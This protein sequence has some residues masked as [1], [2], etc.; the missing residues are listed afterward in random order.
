MVRTSRLSEQIAHTLSGYYIKIIYWSSFA[1]LRITSRVSLITKCIALCGN[2]G[3]IEIHADLG[4]AERWRINLSRLAG[5]TSSCVSTLRAP[6]ILIASVTNRTDL[7]APLY[8]AANSVLPRRAQAYD[9]IRGREL[10][11]GLGPTMESGRTWA[12][13]TG[14]AICMR[15]IIMY[16]HPRDPPRGLEGDLVCRGGETS[17]A[18]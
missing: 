16:N 18:T 5:A 6:S 4:I 2:I 13:R 1:C 17:G 14:A 9:G 10:I 15:P 8:R 12:T 7:S 11:R 3:N